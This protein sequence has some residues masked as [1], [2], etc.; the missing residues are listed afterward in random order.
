MT[1]SLILIFLRLTQVQQE[2]ERY[3]DSATQLRSENSAYM[4]NEMKQK[5]EIDK[6][7]AMFDQ[8]KCSEDSLRQKSEN[9][10]KEIERLKL[11]MERGIQKVSESLFLL[12][13]VYR[14]STNTITS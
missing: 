4:Q 14:R 13:W 1:V 8:L 11:K 5:M 9:S 6:L 2:L 12:I 10:S 3:K 7:S